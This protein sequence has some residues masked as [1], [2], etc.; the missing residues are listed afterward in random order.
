[1]KF[2]NQELQNSFTAMQTLGSMP[3][4]ASVAFLVGKAMDKLEACAQTFDNARK[5][6]V[7]DYAER[8]DKGEM[9]LHPGTNNAVVNDT[10]GFLKDFN[11][12][13]AEET[14]EITFT[15]I[16]IERLG[17]V[18]IPPAVLNTLKWL[19]VE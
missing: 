10:A 18:E 17:D 15:P 8:D 14:D 4:K 9:V 12:L 11:D 5:K 1:M 6:L 3:F 16:K 13:L 19:I 7:E 2:T